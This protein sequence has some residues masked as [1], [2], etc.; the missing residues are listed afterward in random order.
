M[1]LKHG[2]PKRSILGVVG[3]NEAYFLDLH[4]H[5]S[6]SDMLIL[7]YVSC[8]VGLGPRLLP[9]VHESI[10]HILFALNYTVCCEQLYALI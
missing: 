5:A 3:K 4:C 1:L 10:F 2:K 6:F 9:A 8:L 7:M